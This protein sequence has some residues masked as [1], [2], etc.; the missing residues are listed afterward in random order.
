MKK[1]SLTLK[2]KVLVIEYDSIIEMEIDE[3]LHK[4][5]PTNDLTLL[6]SPDDLKEED[7]EDLVEYESKFDNFNRLIEGYKGNGYLSKTALKPFLESIEKEIYWE[8][9]FGKQPNHMDYKFEKYPNEFHFK[10]ESHKSRY[11]NAFEKWQ[12]AELGTFDR[13][14]TLIFVEN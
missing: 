3:L 11:G 12:V 2:R 7:V 10:S 14:R 4:G 8:N 5:L 6:G 13:T 1:I 9:P